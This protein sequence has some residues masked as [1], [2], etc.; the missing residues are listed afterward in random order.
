MGIDTLGHEN[1]NDSKLE[2]TAHSAL[3]KNEDNINSNRFI[4][5]SANLLVEY[6]IIPVIDF[7]SA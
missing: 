2:D 7:Y 3:N 1:T 6:T 5:T 4:V